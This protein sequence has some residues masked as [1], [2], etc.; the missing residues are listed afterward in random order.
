MKTHPPELWDQLRA[1]Y[2]PQAPELDVDS[3]MA[4]VRREAAGTRGSCLSSSLRIA[5]NPV[6]AIPTWACAL[7]AS[8]AILAAASIINGSIRD[9][10]RQI[11]HAWMRSVQPDDFA[12]TFLP[13]DGSI[14]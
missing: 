8:L 11:G 6:P 13:F 14:L 7:A 2:R 12:Q 9:A 3:I 4:A 5:P 10:D 1:G